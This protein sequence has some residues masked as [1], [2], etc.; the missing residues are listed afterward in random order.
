MSVFMV[1]SIGLLPVSLAVGGVLAQWSVAWMFVIAGATTVAVVAA[2][3]T[4][5][6]LREIT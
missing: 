2:A 1:T 3:T 5:S 4:L 6:T